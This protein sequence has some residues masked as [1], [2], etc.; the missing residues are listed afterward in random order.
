[1]ICIKLIEF[2]LL[3]FQ[4][5]F[6]FFDITPLGRILN[7]FS[8]DTYTID[9]SLPFMLNIFLA[10]IFGLIGALCVSLY[11][12]PWLALVIIPMCPIY[13]NIQSRYR[14]SSRDIRRLSSNA[15]R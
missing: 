3:F 4:T 10:A 13:L 6:S 5:E 14:Q 12:M 7:R 9:D 15:M 1:M 8:S 2:I 11:A